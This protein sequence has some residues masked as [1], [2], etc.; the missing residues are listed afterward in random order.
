MSDNNMADLIRQRHRNS[1]PPREMPMTA[2][3]PPPPAEPPSPEVETSIS[4]LRLDKELK[5]EMLN[6][7]NSEDPRLT[8]EVLVE[9]LYLSAQANGHVEKALAIARDRL[10]QR[11]QAGVQ[12]RAKT[13]AQNLQ[14]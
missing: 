5:A 14:S 11:K 12:K 6:L 7:C 10:K 8:L 4:T 2:A 1:V 3:P 13:Y 9:G